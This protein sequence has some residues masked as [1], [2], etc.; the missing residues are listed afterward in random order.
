MAWR[1]TKLMRD[2]EEYKQALAAEPQ[3]KEF[4]ERSAVIVGLE[5]QNLQSGSAIVREEQT[6]VSRE[7]RKSLNDFR[8]S[9]YGMLQRRS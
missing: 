2:S 3:L 1:V 7:S 6:K 8:L 9:F 5:R 4:F